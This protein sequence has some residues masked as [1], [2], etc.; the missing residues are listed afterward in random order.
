[1]IVVNENLIKKIVQKN[2]NYYSFFS[3]IVHDLKH[4]NYVF[5]WQ[6]EIFGLEY[7]EFQFYWSGKQKFR[8]DTKKRK[9]K[10]NIISLSYFKLMFCGSLALKFFRGYYKRINYLVYE[11]IGTKLMKNQDCG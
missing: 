10:K 5:I 11:K 3:N 2:L 8:T 7:S 4:I 1:M 6:A 9:G